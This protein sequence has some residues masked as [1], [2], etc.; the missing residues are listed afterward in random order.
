MNIFKK[1]KKIFI[2][3]LAT[4]IL[5]YPVYH[6]LNKLS[7]RYRV[8]QVF[9]ER[10]KKDLQSV[11]GFFS[12][13]VMYIHPGQDK[14]EAIQWDDQLVRLEKESADEVH[15]S[16]IT[17]HIIYSI[18]VSKDSGGTWDILHKFDVDTTGCF[19]GTIYKEKVNCIAGWSDLLFVDKNGTFT[20]NTKKLLSDS[21]IIERILAIYT[22]DSNKL[23]FVWRDQ[24]AQF[25]TLNFS[26]PFFYGPYLIIAGELN[27]DTLEFKEHIIGYDKYNL[28][29][30]FG[31][32]FND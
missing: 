19:S 18:R 7:Y 29:E 5:I 15:G 8:D 1:Y 10:A 4:V 14:S 16:D 13:D 32:D 24:R 22:K 21:S 9:T 3:I 2:I 27:L 17:G 12:K 28:E 31:K 25:S 11:S 30:L 23:I 6:V 20:K 26:P